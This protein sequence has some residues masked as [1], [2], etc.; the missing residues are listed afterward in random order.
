MRRA[1]RIEWLLQHPWAMV[2]IA[3]ILLA[4]GAFIV[5]ENIQETKTKDAERRRD[6]AKG[7]SI[8]ND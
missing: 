5:W 4:I 6:R 8:W 1:N 3:A 2:L 7:D